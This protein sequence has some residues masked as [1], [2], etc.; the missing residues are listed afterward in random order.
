MQRAVD[1]EQ[2]C[3]DPGGEENEQQGYRHDDAHVLQADRR[4]QQEAK[5]AL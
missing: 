2:E 5:T 4:H 3:A 1:G